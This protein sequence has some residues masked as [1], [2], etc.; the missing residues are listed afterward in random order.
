MA[1]WEPVAADRFPAQHTVISDSV[2]ATIQP[3][4][5]A[6]TLGLAQVEIDKRTT[7]LVRSEFTPKL[8]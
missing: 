7:M 8:A 5:G 3:L 6:V 2:I 1:G 4:P